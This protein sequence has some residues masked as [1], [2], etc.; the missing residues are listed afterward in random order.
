MT[1]DYLLIGTVLKPQGIRGEVK[2][3]SFAADM[4]RF[5]SWRTLYRFGPEGMEAM[6][7]ECTRIHD[8]FVYLIL[9]DTAS[10]DDAEKLRG[11][12]LYIHRQD[13]PA[14]R[15]ASETLICDLIGCSG[16]TENGEIIGTLTDVLQHGPVDVYVFATPQGE[17]M[18][19]ALKRVFPKVDVA[20][21][22]I[23]VVL[24]EL[25]QVAVREWEHDEG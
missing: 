7:S 17:L 23:Q 20:A 15:N 2:V 11:I 8:G 6:K 5:R 18:A 22:Q 9:Q 16:V 25:N 21:R 24:D 13:V 4:E 12:S 19:P 10:A 3:K 14:P 1:K